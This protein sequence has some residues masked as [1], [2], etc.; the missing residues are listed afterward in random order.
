M[1]SS[2][3]V[4]I[5]LVVWALVSSATWAQHSDDQDVFE[6][7][8]SHV[9]EFAGN[10]IA[11]VTNKLAQRAEFEEAEDEYDDELSDGLVP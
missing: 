5:F 2:K 9:Q 6:D 10:V 7:L 3:I 11:A 8:V 4:C 1:M